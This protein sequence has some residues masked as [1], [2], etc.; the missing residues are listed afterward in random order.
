MTLP[1]VCINESNCV[2]LD[3]TFSLKLPS[4]S[5]PEGVLVEYAD[6]SSPASSPSISSPDSDLR[7]AIELSARAQEEEEKLRK[8]EDEE[9]ERILQ[10][11]LTEK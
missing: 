9:L 11:S 6:T 10:L 7:L 8:Q 2:E 1:P 4:R 3:L 5:V